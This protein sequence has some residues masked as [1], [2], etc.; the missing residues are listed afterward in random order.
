MGSGEQDEEEVEDVTD[1]DEKMELRI[2]ERR[3]EMCACRNEVE[4]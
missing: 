3:T 1:Y 2:A 4:R